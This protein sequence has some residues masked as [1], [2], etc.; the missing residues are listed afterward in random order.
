MNM[1]AITRCLVTSVGCGVAFSVASAVADQVPDAQTQDPTLSPAQPS[2]P[3]APGM[4]V[5]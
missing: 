1:M 4:S 3:P 2:K 5:E